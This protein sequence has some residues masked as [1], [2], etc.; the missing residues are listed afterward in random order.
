MKKLEPGC[1]AIVKGSLCNDGKIVQCISFI[2]KY[3]FRN[4]GGW[5]R[6]DVPAWKCSP[7]TAYDGLKVD[8]VP[9][10]VLFPID[11]PDDDEKDEF[12]QNIPDPRFE[13]AYAEAYG[14]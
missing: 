2:P 8:V 9:A 6:K 5:I 7:A 11:N 13:K 10:N 14:Q 12:Y 3:N 4:P 1:L